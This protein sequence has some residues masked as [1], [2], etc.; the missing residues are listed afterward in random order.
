V[1]AVPTNSGALVTYNNDAKGYVGGLEVLLKYKPDEQFFGWLAYTLSRAVRQYGPGQPDVL[2]PWDQTHILTVLGSYRLGWGWEFGARFR[3]VSGNLV[4]PNVCDFAATTCD[5]TRINALFHGATG[6][7]TPI[8]FGGDQGE[9]LPMFHQLDLR[10]DKTWE[11]KAWKLSAYLDILNAYNS[12]NVEAIIYDYR[13]S[14]R[15]FVTGIPILPS[16]GLRG[17]F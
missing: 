3:L 1:V 2:M 6:A 16:F 12:Q 10:V 5:P 14:T 8:P 17:E 11:F 7:Y 4:D 15:Q 13:F 9:R